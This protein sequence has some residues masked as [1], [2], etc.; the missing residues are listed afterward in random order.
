MS[1]FHALLFTCG[2]TVIRATSFLII[3]VILL[4]VDVGVMPQTTGMP[5]PMD[6]SLH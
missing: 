3:V 5:M 2:V 6:I 1:L 4:V